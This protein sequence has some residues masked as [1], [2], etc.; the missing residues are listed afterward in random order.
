[1]EFE[2]LFVIYLVIMFVVIGL[3][4]MAIAENKE[5]RK[6]NERMKKILIWRGYE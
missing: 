2:K 1:M 3:L 6:D 5:L 4:L